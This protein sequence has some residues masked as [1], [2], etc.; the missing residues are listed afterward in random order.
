MR[1]LFAAALISGTALAGC[2]TVLPSL[3]LDTSV[4]L[5]TIYGIENAYGVAVN[6]ANAYRAL[7]L[8][9][10]GAVPSASNSQTIRH[11]ESAGGDAA[12]AAGRQ[13]CRCFPE[14]LSGCRRDERARRRADRVAR[15]S[16]DSRLRSPMDMVTVAD[17]EAGVAI[18]EAIVTA[19]VKV[20][21]AIEQGIVS[22]VPY[23]QAIAG[24]IQG[25]NATQQQIDV[26]LA[27]IEGFASR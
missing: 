8:C 6:A 7:P 2:Q 22:S 11:G 25:S 24:L 12:R 20:A 4:T 18:A 21:P 27:Q 15:R 5:N 26:T 13:Q 16:A 10:T 17:I 14:S 19:I 9:K 3:N 23:V 1:K